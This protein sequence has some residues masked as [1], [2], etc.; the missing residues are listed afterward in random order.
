MA[1][2]KGHARYYLLRNCYVSVIWRALSIYY[3]IGSHDNPMRS[4]IIQFL[5][6]DEKLVA[7][8]LRDVSKILELIQGE[9]KI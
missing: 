7:Q 3:F 2:E 9:D 5:P 6:P 1:E 8:Q 4:V